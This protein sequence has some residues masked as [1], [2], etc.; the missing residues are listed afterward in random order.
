[1]TVVGGDNRGNN[2]LAGN[3]G[4][5]NIMAVTRPNRQS[6]YGWSLARDGSWQVNPKRG[7]TIAVKIRRCTLGKSQAL[8]NIRLSS[9]RMGN[10]VVRTVFCKQL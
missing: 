8:L 10:P 5:P 9:C 1:M 4:V 6:R 7:E 2:S 3:T